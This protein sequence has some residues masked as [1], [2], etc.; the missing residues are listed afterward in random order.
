MVLATME[1]HNSPPDNPIERRRTIRIKRSGLTHWKLTGI[2]RP[3]IKFAE[4]I[5]EREQA[6]RMLHDTYLKVGYIKEPRPSG[7]LFSIYSLLPDTVVFVA[8]SY[9]SVISSL[10][11][12][13]DS[14]EFGL[15]MDV[16]YQNE[17]DELRGQGR[18]IVELSALVTPR[19]L[20]WRNIF[21]YLSQ[22]MYQYS[23]YSGV[24]DLCIAVNP[25]HVRFYKNIFLFE[26]F[27]PERH[28]P[29]VDAPAIALRIN[30]HNIQEQL[31]ETYDSL[32]LDCNLYAYFHRMTG[33]LPA[34]DPDFSPDNVNVVNLPDP[35]ETGE[36]MVKY[37]MAKEPCVV[38]G[39]TAKQWEFLVKVYPS[40]RSIYQHPS[41]PITQ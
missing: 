10:T 32:D 31:K 16:I 28:Y 1:N 37:F 23:I 12:I 41:H 3:A 19:K 11:E 33:F 27:G 40:L 38:D 2:D 29:R 24:D 39:L 7:L 14:K 17:L 34:N 4:T 21:M 30:M 35:S 25:K 13:F 15:P 26:P 20:R 18:R 6:F 5:D 8:K 36:E 22:I 9:L